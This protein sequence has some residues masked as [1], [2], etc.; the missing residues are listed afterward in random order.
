MSEDDSNPLRRITAEPEEDL[1]L[2]VV[3]WWTRAACLETRKK[4][5]PQVKKDLSYITEARRICRMCPVRSECLSYAL[6]YPVT[7]QHGVWGGLTPRQLAAEAK[8]RGVTDTKP[9]LAQL[10]SSY[11]GK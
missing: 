9:T 7:D 8:R 11:S 5:F 1:S 4:M 3:D 10:W 6:T 2:E